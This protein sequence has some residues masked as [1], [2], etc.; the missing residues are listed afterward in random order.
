MKK[1]ALILASVAALSMPVAMAQTTDSSMEDPTVNIAAQQLYQGSIADYLME[2]NTLLNN[3]TTVDASGDFDKL[4]QAATA[5]GLLETLQGDGAYTLFAPTNAAFENAF[6][7]AEF[8]A[9][10]Q[11]TTTLEAVLKNHIVNQEL[12][13]NDMYYSADLNEYSFE[14]LDGNTLMLSFPANTEAASQEMSEV[15][16]GNVD[17]LANRPHIIA[18]TVVTNNG[19]ILV[20]DELLLPAQ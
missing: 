10:L 20:I 14:T 8:E 18:D 2:Q 3:D 1:Q 13:L 7:D 6:T 12:T 17:M 5:A 4:I 15:T 19:T 16:I 11:D 9:L